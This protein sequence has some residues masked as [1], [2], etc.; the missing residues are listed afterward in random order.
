M[1]KTLKMG[2]FHKTDK[3]SEK[4]SFWYADWAFPIMTAMMAA[5]IFAGTHMYFTTGVGAFNDIPIVALLKSGMETGS[6]GAAAAFG[7]SFLFARILEGSLVGIMDIGGSMMTGIGVGVPAMLLSVGF[8][9]P[10]KSFPVAL[11]TGALLGLA[12]G[13]VIISVR[14]TTVNS[15]KEQTSTFGADIM[16]GAG[17]TTGRFFGPLIIISACQASI[18]V[19]IGSLLGALIFYKMDKPIVGGAILGAMVMGFLFPIPGK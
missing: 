8:T 9:L 14:R 3:K 10:L 19:G 13:L 17:N 6:Y 11:V 15:T 16:M 5:G 4:A 1:D 12:V 7:A 18:P 2:H